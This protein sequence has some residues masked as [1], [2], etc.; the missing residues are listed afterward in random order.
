MSMEKLNKDLYEEMLVSIFAQLKGVEHYSY[1]KN[2]RT[3][4]VYEVSGLKLLS[5]IDVCLEYRLR[6]SVFGKNG[7]IIRL[8]EMKDE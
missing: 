5:L 2:I 4:Y 8:G 1:F 6:Y 7:L 3:I